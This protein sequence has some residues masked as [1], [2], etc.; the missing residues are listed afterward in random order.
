MNETELTKPDTPPAPDEDRTLQSMKSLH[1][2]AEYIT[3]LQKDLGDAFTVQPTLMPPIHFFGTPEAARDIRDQHENMDVGKGNALIGS[4]D[5]AFGKQSIVVLDGEEHALR[6]KWI[7]K[8]L[9]QGPVL[10]LL[11]HWRPDIRLR[12]Q[13]WP[14]ARRFRLYDEVRRLAMGMMTSVILG[15]GGEE[16]DQFVSDLKRI[17]DSVSNHAFWLANQKRL[18]RPISRKI[19]SLIAKRR[20]NPGAD[21]LSRLIEGTADFQPDSQD[22]HD[23][24]LTLL[25][26]GH[27]GASATSSWIVYYLSTHTDW[28]AASLP[29]IESIATAE[30][31]TRALL[32]SATTL[33]KVI[34]ETLR[35]RPVLVGVQR[36]PR[37]PVKVDTWS[38]KPECVLSPS[39]YMVHHHEDNWPQPWEFDPDR[40][41]QE[42]ADGAWFPFGLA[43]RM[44]PGR[45]V[46]TME[47][48]IL[49]SEILHL[50]NGRISHPG[51]EPGIS[52]R[53]NILMPSEGL[54]TLIEPL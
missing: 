12:L 51:Y 10:D 38:L 19:Y 2:P 17:L 8:A 32:D 26:L 43:P 13:Q 7:E 36:M 41:Q 1:S 18:S 6:R 31:V 44:C 42:P 34:K 20:D 52:I 37:C 4:F 27:E 15:I 49:S 54:P 3:E 16:R 9:A 25:T 53:G 5:L 14:V 24:V 33:D 35:I 28:L 22:L 21:V 47:M 46:G 39:M 23:N 29:D 45:S 11:N 30:T 40:F 50:F 48:K